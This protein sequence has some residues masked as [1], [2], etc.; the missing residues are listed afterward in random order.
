MKK[1][2]SLV[3]LLGSLTLLSFFFSCESISD[4]DT[5]GRVVS[6]GIDAGMAIAKAAEPITPE[7][8][9]YIGRSVAATLLQSYDLAD[10]V[11]LTAYLNKICMALVIHSERPELYNGYH[12]SILDS[13]QINAFATSGGHILITRGL[14]SCAE[15]EDALASVIAHEIGHIQLQHSLKAIKT[16]RSS[17]AALATGGLFL[18]LTGNED[19][20]DLADMMDASI[21]EVITTMVNK[22]YSK[23]Q[24]YDADA[25]AVKLLFDAGY[26]PHAIISMLQVLQEKQ[27]RSS[28]GFAK[29]HPSAKQRI[30]EANKVLKKYATI[31]EA[32]NRN[33][34]FNETVFL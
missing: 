26:N 23:Q 25:A 6:S 15:N 12:V 27:P 1:A 13:D 16:S 17:Q 32:I 18:N 28:G 8:E 30:K 19:L 34:R 5:L 24:E 31:P 22:G 21:N 11:K 10:E 33:K 2:K 29:T 9:Y 14:L 3:I 7:Q 4:F 20:M